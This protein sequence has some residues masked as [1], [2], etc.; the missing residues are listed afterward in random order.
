M[1]GSSSG[2][3]TALRSRLSAVF[4]STRPSVWAQGPV[5][6]RPH[7]VSSSEIVQ[8]LRA[9]GFDGPCQGG[10][11][12]YIAGPTGCSHCRVLLDRRSAS[13]IWSAS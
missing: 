7:P 8:L 12:P 13:T 10:R 3:V 4:G 1:I 6:D 11:H 9:L 2:S 5:A